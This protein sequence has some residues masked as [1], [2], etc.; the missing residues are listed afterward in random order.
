MSIIGTPTTRHR[1]LSAARRT[2]SRR[3]EAH[4]AAKAYDFRRPI[5]LSRE[6]ARILQVGFDSL[7]RQATTLFTSAL[8]TV[9]QVTLASIEQRSYA[10]YID[11]LRPATYMT[12]FD[13]DPM[14]GVGILELQIP[15]TMTCVDHMLG[16]P[17]TTNQP[18]RPLTEIEAGVIGGLIERFLAEMRYAL[19]SIVTLEPSVLGVEYSPQFVQAAS[20]AD[21]MVVVTLE[22]RI[23]EVA[24]PMTICLPFNGLLPY[25]AA[26]GA[27]APTSERERTK[28]QAAAVKLRAQFAEV[29]MPVSIRF[30]STQ[31]APSALA[32]LQ[33]GEVLR[34]AHPASAPLDVTVD[35]RVFAHASA[36]AAGE[37]LA[38][39][40]V[41]TTKEPQ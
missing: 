18:E 30:R 8:R 28:R 23:D 2:R 1:G 6:H 34:L 35:G 11:S 41:G 14:P 19:G 37:R 31:V 32:Q 16:G 40:I 21:V 29:Q 27:P 26:A 33:V 24:H 15:A 7:S 20:A 12:K 13:A 38:A 17:G 25:L 4:A 22:L 39:L 3:R 10:E 5:Q 9:C 36:G